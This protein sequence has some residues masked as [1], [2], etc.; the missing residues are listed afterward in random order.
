MKIH[1]FDELRSFIFRTHV[2][3][4]KPKQHILESLVK[5]AESPSADILKEHAVGEQGLSKKQVQSLFAKYGANLVVREKRKAWP[6]RLF[7][8]ILNPLVLLLLALG[9][10]SI[11]TS[12]IATAIIIFAMVLISVSIRFVQENSAYSSAQALRKMVHTTCAVIRGGVEQEINIDHVV[13]GDILQLNAGDIV[14]ADARIISSKDLFVN[15]SLLTGEALPVEKHATLPLG[16]KA[17]N[18]LEYQNICLMGS[19]VESGTAR[20][21]VVATG[22]L[23]F[24]GS[25][26]KDIVGEREVTSFDRGINKFTW[27]MMG[28]MGI[29]VPV[30]FIINGFSKHD[31]GEAFL[32]AVSVAVGLTPEMLPALVTVNLSKGAIAMAKK[33]VIV[34]HLSAIQNFGAMNVLCSDKT[35]TLT[36]NEVVLIKNIDINGAANDGVLRSAF[37]NSFYQT[38]FKNLLDGAVLKHGKDKNIEHLKE[39]FKK[40]DE[41]PF[42]FQR[43]RVS[44]VV[45]DGKHE[46][47]MFCKGA[48]EEVVALC[49]KYVLDGV[50]HDFDKEST[51]KL[52]NLERSLSAEGYQVLAVAERKITDPKKAYTK[53]DEHDLALL[54]FM[55]FLD[56]AKESAIDA[57]KQLTEHG[58]AVKIL[59]GDN[60][61]VTKKICYDV[62]LDG[63]TGILL[64]KDIE[65]MSD[66]EL[67]KVVVQTTIFAKLLPDHKRRVVKSLQRNDC[68]VGF[69]G[70]G[71]NDAPALRT[72]D[73]GISVDTAVDISKE[74]A[75]IILLEMSLS[76]LGDGVIEGRKVFGNIMKYI[77]MGASSNFGNMFSVLGA[78]VL[79]PFLPMTPVQILTNNL[80]Y[81][82][83]QTTIPT[84]NVDEEYIKVPRKWHISDVGR[85]MLFIGPVSSLF[86]YMTFAV[87]WFIF[88]ANTAPALLQTG[89][90]VE[91]LLTQTL[92]VHV[93]RSRKI[94]FL[95]TWASKPLVI[96]T[97][98]VIAAGVALTFS[99]I[100]K[101]LGMQRLPQLY[102]PILGGMM[103]MYML[104]TQL[105]KT[106]YIKKYGY[107]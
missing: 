54:G 91:S 96:S 63:T 50:E 36:R 17:D 3:G 20:A 79:I 40:V 94:P 25:L 53:E 8:I 76:V 47:Y 46:Q 103:I 33:K 2:A 21:V 107:N 101:H 66:E 89:W 26:A 23:T 44:L 27:L 12:D 87:M 84:D 93:I 98:L 64:G 52:W 77:K 15:Q 13:P 67:D 106:W 1:Y 72:A 74:S 97:A 105:I 60:E 71:I 29:M 18:P 78:S 41:L 83:S 31:W 43:R 10:V 5:A 70:D 65:R 73:V 49:T 22:G 7:K 85:Y 75:D 28:F 30:V 6:I 11:F 61:L 80:L 4:E 48:S 34:K 99:P 86:D 39:E 57:I 19:N 100:A 35:G 81:D 90:F 82:F 68:V 45:E 62:G 69:M 37:L 51:D 95:Q 92:I 88:H 104:L 56:P 24:F 32:F 16:V 102:W 9:G 42:D 38:G 55:A 58:V 14:P 59:T